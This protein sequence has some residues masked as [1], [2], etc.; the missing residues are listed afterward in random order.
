M[1]ASLLLGVGGRDDEH[2]QD[3]RVYLIAGGDA[4]PKV[5]RPILVAE[6][7]KGS[8]LPLTQGNILKQLKLHLN[9][10]EQKWNKIKANVAEVRL[11]LAEE[12]ERRRKEAEEARKQAEEEAEKLEETLKSIPKTDC[13]ED[14]DRGV[15]KQTIEE[16]AGDV[17]K[18]GDQV[19]A[20]Y[21]G[22]LLDGT[23]FD[24]SRD[25]EETFKFPLGASQVIRCWDMAFATMKVGEKAVLTCQPEYAYGERGSPPT[26]PPDATLRFDVEL[27]SFTSTAS[28]EK[29]EL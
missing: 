28:N 18:K 23:K 7:S 24:S 21:T 29:D 11:Q 5:R 26:I 9:E 2:W 15:I 12:K 8:S 25:R 17:P 13:S 19:E 27:V 4:T 6:A 22:T 16:G 20:H 14:E 1:L 10:I 3:C